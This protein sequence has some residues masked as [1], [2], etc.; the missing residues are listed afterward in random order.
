VCCLTVKKE[1]PKFLK[2]PD[3]VEVYEYETVRMETLVSGK[4]QPAVEWLRGKER[5]VPDGE[6]IVYEEEGEKYTLVVKEVKKE[7]AGMITVAAT[8]DQGTMSASARLK[9]T[10]KWGLGHRGARSHISGGKVTG[11]KGHT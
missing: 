3:N 1:M 7:E 9:V 4:P 5:I 10:R 11:R 6:R 2:K 8:N